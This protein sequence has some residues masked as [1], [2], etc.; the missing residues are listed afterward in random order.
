MQVIAW[1]LLAVVAIWRYIEN[2]QGKHLVV[3]AVALALMISTMEISFIYLAILAG[4]LLLRVFLS[5]GLSWKKLSV[6]LNSI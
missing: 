2:R 4:Y 3:L 6:T 5:T 1:L